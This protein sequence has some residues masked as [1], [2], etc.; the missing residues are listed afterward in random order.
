M[1]LEEVAAST[2]DAMML[3]ATSTAATSKE[4]TVRAAM[5]QAV[6]AAVASSNRVVP[7]GPTNGVAPPSVPFAPLTPL[8]QVAPDWLLAGSASPMLGTSENAEYELSL[9][10]HATK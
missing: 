6:F 10:N 1:D 2:T 3:A 9:C 4:D 7:V 5:V 8:A